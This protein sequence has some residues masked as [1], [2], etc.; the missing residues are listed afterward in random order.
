MRLREGR[1]HLGRRVTMRTLR[2]LVPAAVIAVVLAV[3]VRAGEEG[4]KKVDLKK[5]P[6]AVLKAVKAKFPGAKLLGASTEEEKGK[7]VY[8]IS[9]TYKGHHHDVTL[10]PDGKIV[11]IEREI[12]AKDLPKVVADGVAA[13]YPKAKYKKAE[14]LIKGDGALHGYEVVITSGN[15]TVEVVLDL[16]GKILR[17]ETKKKAAD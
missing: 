15:D 12:P 16:K 13:K 8:E 11:S 2:W 1:T 4:E 5:V 9:L 3:H 7:T 10:E 17:E 6:K 14:E